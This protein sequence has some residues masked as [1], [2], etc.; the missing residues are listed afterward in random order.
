MK[1]NVFSSGEMIHLNH[2]SYMAR[3]EYAKQIEHYR[4][5]FPNSTIKV[6][7]F[8]TL[9]S[10]ESNI[11]EFTNICN[12]IGIKSIVYPKITNKKYNSSSAERLSILNELIWRKNRWNGLRKI[13]GWMLPS[14]EIK[15]NIAYFLDYI[16]KRAVT[17]PDDW[18]KKVDNKFLIEAERQTELLAQAT[19]LDFTCWEK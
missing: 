8:E 9:F 2:H 17:F 18:R 1:K 4:K 7:R 14:R 5:I 13:V 3:G 6:I 11:Q 16:N 15:Y 12:F 19:G 10:K